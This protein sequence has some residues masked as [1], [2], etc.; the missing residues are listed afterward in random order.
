MIYFEKFVSILEWTSQ[1]FPVLYFRES[2][3]AVLEFLLPKILSFILFLCSMFST[4]DGLIDKH[5]P[6]KNA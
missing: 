2:G 6:S 5:S 4:K 3:F 1:L